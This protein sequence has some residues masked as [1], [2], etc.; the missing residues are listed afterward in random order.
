[1]NILK[2]QMMLHWSLDPH[3]RYWSTDV[4]DGFAPT[5]RPAIIWTND[6]EITDAYMRHLASMS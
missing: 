5:R 2:F 3:W 6:G 4:D 1:M